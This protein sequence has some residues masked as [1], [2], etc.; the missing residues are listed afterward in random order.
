MV[1]ESTVGY[2]GKGIPAYQA[3]PEVGREVVV[4]KTQQPEV[5]QFSRFATYSVKTRKKCKWCGDR[6]SRGMSVKSRGLIRDFVCLPC[7][8]EANIWLKQTLDLGTAPQENK[9]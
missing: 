8:F 4:T 7:L 6:A 5:P 2:Q 3:L 1:S 9:P